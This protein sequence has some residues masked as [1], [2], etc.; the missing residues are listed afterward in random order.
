[1]PATPAQ[2]PTGL[3]YPPAPHR[4]TAPRPLQELCK[5]ELKRGILGVDPSLPSTITAFPPG[6]IDK[7]KEVGGCC[8]VAEGCW[9]W[10]A[11]GVL[12]GWALGD[13]AWLPPGLL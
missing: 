3:P 5:E 7:D 4:I 1:M 11:A 8:G 13:P 2:L 12:G 9:V 10:G 6:Y